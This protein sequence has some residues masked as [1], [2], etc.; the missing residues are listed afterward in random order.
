M[1]KRQ[2]APVKI[3]AGLIVRVIRFRQC[4]CNALMST[5]SMH[6]VAHLVGIIRLK[7][8]AVFVMQM[9]CKM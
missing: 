2:P 1:T 4:A 5:S 7:K 6:N 8:I 9:T 3:D